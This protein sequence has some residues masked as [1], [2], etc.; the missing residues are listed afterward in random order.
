MSNGITAKIG[1]QLISLPGM[2]ADA[3]ISPSSWDTKVLKT[4]LRAR[5]LGNGS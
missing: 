5:D 3:K 4:G 1:R 2:M